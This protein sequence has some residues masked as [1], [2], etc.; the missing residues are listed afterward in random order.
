M[1]HFIYI[2]IQY[3]KGLVEINLKKKFK[4]KNKKNFKTVKDSFSKVYFKQIAQFYAY[5][6]IFSSTNPLI[7]KESYFQM[8]I[9]KRE[10]D[11][12]T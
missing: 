1:G 5:L 3:R 9:L 10:K 8:E 6:S 11:T 12:Y 7:I 2:E 4:N